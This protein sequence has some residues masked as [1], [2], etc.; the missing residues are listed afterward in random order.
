MSVLKRSAKTVEDFADLRY[1]CALQFPTRVADGA[2]GFKAGSGWSTYRTVWCYQEDI[3]AWQ[4][5][6]T[7]DY[8]VYKPHKK[9]VIRYDPTLPIHKLAEMRILF[10]G[11]GYWVRSVSTPAGVADWYV[12][13]TVGDVRE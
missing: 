4:V 3:P 1:R 7:D 8:D 2:G 5:R 6:S 13:E 9:F 11:H 12:I 10:A